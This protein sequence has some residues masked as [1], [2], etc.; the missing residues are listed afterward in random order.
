MKYLLL[1]AIA[2]SLV[3]SGCNNVVNNGIV[4]DDNGDVNADGAQYLAFDKKEFENAKSENK[5]ILLDFYANWCP[6]CRL[7]NPKIRSALKEFKSNEVVAFQVH[8]NDGDV[9]EEHIALAKEYGINI[10]HTK[11]ILKDGEVALKSL[12]SWSKDT[13]VNELRKVL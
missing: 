13:A 7:E 2:F 10:Q 4:T 12:E 3:F 8:Y 1:L 5:V 9:T 6:V 11:V